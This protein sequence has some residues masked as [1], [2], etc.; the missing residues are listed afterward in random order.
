VALPRVDRITADSLHCPGRLVLWES[1]H[2]SWSAARTDGHA[3]SARE[4]ILIGGARDGIGVDARFLRG[5]PVLNSTL[6]GFDNDPLADDPG[7]VGVL[8]GRSPAGGEGRLLAGG[9]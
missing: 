4:H 3:A 9:R 6:G 7:R 1:I 5:I 2:E 8:V